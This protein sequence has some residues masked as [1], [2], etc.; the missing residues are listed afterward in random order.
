[1]NI[2]SKDISNNFLLFFLTKSYT[3]SCCIF[4]NI[5]LLPASF[6]RSLIKFN[7]M[8]LKN[9]LPIIRLMSSSL[10]LLLFFMIIVI[11]FMLIIIIIILPFF[12]IIRIRTII[13][14]IIIPLIIPIVITFIIL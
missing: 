3:T 7:R 13:I 1:M 4:S 11:I 10:F 6:N 5:I 2:C 8:S 12:I 14:I 9:L